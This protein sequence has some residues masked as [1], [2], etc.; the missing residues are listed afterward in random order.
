[1]THTVSQASK[2]RRP[3]N[4]GD[5]D[6]ILL[7]IDLETRTYDVL[8]DSEL[9][10]LEIPDWNIGITVH[11]FSPYG[12]CIDNFLINLGYVIVLRLNFFTN[13]RSCVVQPQW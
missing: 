12:V 1:V 10:R 3:K 7:R 6:R 4:K 11:R 13:A 5:F 8:L 9:P 2:G